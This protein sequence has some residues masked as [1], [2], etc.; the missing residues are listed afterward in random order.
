MKLDRKQALNALPILLKGNSNDD[1]DS[2]ISHL[3]HVFAASGELS[4][5]A[6]NRFVQIK[7]LF[8]QARPSKKEAPA[9][10]NAAKAKAKTSTKSQTATTGVVGKAV[11]SEGASQAKANAEE[12]KP[13]AAK[14]TSVEPSA[15]PDKAEGKATKPSP[16]WWGRF[17]CLCAFWVAVMPV[18]V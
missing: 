7:A 15:A 11:T 1:I 6:A 4:E 8:D 2:Y 13:K 14:L 5:H 9:T 10:P 12:A 17:V 16:I 3:E 18:A